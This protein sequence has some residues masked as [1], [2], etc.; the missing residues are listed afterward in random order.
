MS[1]E[2]L[3]IAMPSDIEPDIRRLLHYQTSFIVLQDEQCVPHFAGN[4]PLCTHRIQAHVLTRLL[5]QALSNIVTSNEGLISKLWDTY[6][7]LPDEDLILV[8][9]T[10]LTAIPT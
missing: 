6:M 3:N 10:Y 5:V 9:V 8:C 7:P 4:L 1:Y 2:Y